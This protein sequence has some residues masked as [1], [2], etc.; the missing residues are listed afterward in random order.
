MSLLY[1]FNVVI[2]SKNILFHTGTCWDNNQYQRIFCEIL[3]DEILYSN[4]VKYNLCFDSSCVV[5]LVENFQ[6]FRSPKVKVNSKH[7]K[8]NS[9]KFVFKPWFPKINSAK[10]SPNV[11]SR[12]FLPRNSQ[13][14]GLR[15]AKISFLKVFEMKWI[16]SSF[17]NNYYVMFS[18]FNPNLGGLFRGSFWGGRRVKLPPPP[19]PLLV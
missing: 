15:F 6:S 4:N 2:K 14:W 16:I 17:S 1:G 19:L 10:L 12:K 11:D 7:S 8:I 13:F 5:Y 9:A 18:N 3:D